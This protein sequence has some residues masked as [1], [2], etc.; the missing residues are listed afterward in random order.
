MCCPAY[1]YPYTYPELLWLIQTQPFSYFRVQ[2]EA[3]LFS[4][5]H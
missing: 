1:P 3:H 2:P 5:S 4:S